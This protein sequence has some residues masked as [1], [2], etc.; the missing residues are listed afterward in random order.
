VSFSFDLHS[1]A[2]FDS[3]MPCRS[4]A[5]PR[6]CRSESDLSRPRQVRG[7][8]TAGERHGMCELASAADLPVLGTVG[9]WQDGGK[10]VAGS[11]HGNGMVC[12]Y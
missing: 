6:L 12:V 11:R 2:V 10:V 5:M 1:S 8:A 3:H 7:R 4:P 9:E